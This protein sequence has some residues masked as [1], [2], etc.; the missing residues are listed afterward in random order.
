[1]PGRSD[2]GPFRIF[3]GPTS[4]SWESTE[5]RQAGDGPIE[6]LVF[7][8]V[9]PS[10]IASSVL[11]RVRPFFGESVGSFGPNSDTSSL[12][13]RPPVIPMPRRPPGVVPGSGWR[14]SRF[15][16]RNSFCNLR[17]YTTCHILPRRADNREN[18]SIPGARR[19]HNDGLPVSPGTL[20]RQRDKEKKRT[21]SG[22][23]FPTALAPS[24]GVVN[25]VWRDG[26]S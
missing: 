2:W 7:E 1:M 6:A 14:N 18:S 26:T 8:F 16:W 11:W 13:C 5:D 23:E 4:R 25:H 3:P 22:K 24:H 17:T 20:R 21:V 9:S 12:G 10:L 19:R 15:I